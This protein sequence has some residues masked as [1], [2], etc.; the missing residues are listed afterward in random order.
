MRSL[1]AWYVI[2]GYFVIFVWLTYCFFAIP[3]R[4]RRYR[5]ENSPIRTLT[6]DE[7]RLLKKY[8]PKEKFSRDVWKLEGRHSSAPF[9]VGRQQLINTIP[10][11]FHPFAYKHLLRR[12]ENAVEVAMGAKKAYVI[13]M[14]GTYSLEGF[15]EEVETRERQQDQWGKGIPG[16]I[17]GHDN[18]RILGQRDSTKEE[19]FEKC[20][21]NAPEF[22]AG[23][24]FRFLG[25]LVS[26]LGLSLFW[27][28]SIGMV[29]FSPFLVLIA[30]SLSFAGA[31][32]M[33]LPA[34]T[35]APA[36]KVN[37]IEGVY[38]KKGW[39]KF[40]VGSMP[41]NIPKKMKY[42][43]ESHVAE[44]EVVRM[45]VYVLSREVVRVEGIASRHRDTVDP[46]REPKKAV[47]IMLGIFA[48]SAIIALSN[49]DSSSAML[50]NHI[51]FGFSSLMTIVY[52]TI[53][54]FKSSVYPS[55][56]QPALDT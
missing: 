45:D 52:G 43:F 13:G 38:G 34:Y 48:V 28:I 5:K 6:L 47:S 3:Q 30:A 29:S 15:A 18:V 50:A 41:I 46:E 54:W 23:K 39:A 10:V 37:I 7:Y 40:L 33:A 31:Y 36:E 42:D 51:L 49:R 22:S 24:E 27:L 53:L 16:E 26:L 2:I 1:A 55:I 44:G 35:M 20:Y 19:R 17:A 21:L 32:P 14:N 12:E 11:V 8:Y 9:W 56:K 25:A 4:A